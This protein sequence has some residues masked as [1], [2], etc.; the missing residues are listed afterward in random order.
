MALDPYLAGLDLAGRRVVVVGAGRVAERRLPTLLA[1]GAAVTVIAP[2]AGTVV[3]RLS[4]AGELV[5]IPRGYAD[6]DL[7]GCW[8]VL[9]ATD[10]PTVNARVSAEAETAT[11]FC[12]RSD[13][14]TAGSAWTPATVAEADLLLGL[15]SRNAA[16]HGT[17]GRTR[18][19]RDRLR[20]RLV[21]LLADEWSRP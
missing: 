9:A 6:G 11:I 10:D 14:A 4:D 1:A 19:L 20:E 7:A 16:A 3:S 21:E 18:D 13:D 2:T 5:W 15:L 8:Y 12:V 17:P